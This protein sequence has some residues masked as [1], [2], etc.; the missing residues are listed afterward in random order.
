MNPVK[1]KLLLDAEIQYGRNKTYVHCFPHY[2][3]SCFLEICFK[4]HFRF[5]QTPMALSD[6][7]EHSLL[8]FD[9]S[10]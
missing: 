3:D 8:Y 1:Y 7:V 6:F 4:S 5:N 9:F 10:G 2:S